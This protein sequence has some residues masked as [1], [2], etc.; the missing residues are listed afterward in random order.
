MRLVSRAAVL[1]RIVA[2]PS[3]RLSSSARAASASVGVGLHAGALLAHEE[4]DDLELRAVGGAELAPLRLGLDLAHLAREDRDDGCV[5]VARTRALALPRLGQWSSSSWAVSGSPPDRRWRCSGPLGASRMPPHAVRRI[6]NRAAR[7]PG[8]RGR[9]KNG[10]VGR[11]AILA[12]TGA[13][14]GT[15]GAGGSD[16]AVR[17]R[18]SRPML[19]PW[20]ISRGRAPSCPRTTNSRSRRTPSSTRTSSR[21]TTTTGRS[22]T[23]LADDVDG[24]DAERRVDLGDERVADDAG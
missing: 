6:P 13:R 11:P 22:T 3:R 24:I 20:T 18:V 8:S 9:P 16:E 5:V 12:A 15:N 10:F 4:R 14:P 7:E 1:A 23:S 19:Q 2:T 17:R 21:P